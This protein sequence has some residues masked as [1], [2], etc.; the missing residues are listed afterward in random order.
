MSDV[1]KDATDWDDMSYE[2]QKDYLMQH[3]ESS[4]RI[5]ARH[6]SAGGIAGGTSMG[7]SLQGRSEHITDNLSDWFMTGSGSSKSMKHLAAIQREF[8]KEARKWDELTKEMQREYLTRH[9]G[10]K[11]R[12]TSRRVREEGVRDF[13]DTSV[14]ASEKKRVRRFDKRIKNVQDKMLEVDKKLNKRIDRALDRANDSTWGSSDFNYYHMRAKQLEE[15]RDQLDREFQ[16]AIESL[17]GKR[18]KIDV[19]MSW[20]SS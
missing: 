18:D 11:R 16:Y 9:P 20:S 19:T 12:V 2:A 8:V 5:T 7:P 1:K 14:S 4:R 15:K 17:R 3:P 13:K 6:P 10:S